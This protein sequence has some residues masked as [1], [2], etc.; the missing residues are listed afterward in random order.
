[1]VSIQHFLFKY[2]SIY[3]FK[4][5]IKEIILYTNQVNIYGNK[6]LV[7]MLT[8]PVYINIYR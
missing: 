1:M 2:F 7:T 4:K 6:L 5:N 8:A 3:V